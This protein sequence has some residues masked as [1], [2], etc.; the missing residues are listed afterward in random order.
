MLG[1]FK[2]AEVNS[3]KA[4]GPPYCH[5]YDDGSLYNGHF[6]VID[7]V[8]YRFEGDG[9]YLQDGSL[10]GILTDYYYIPDSCN[11]NSITLWGAL[12]IDVNGDSKGPNERGRDIFYFHVLDDGNLLPINSRNLQCSNGNWNDKN[13][14]DYG[15]G[16][17]G[18]SST[19]KWN[20][21]CAARIIEEG[22]KMN[23]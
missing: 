17:G 20:D 2:L 14:K 8:N 19:N 9:Y 23:Y 3:D 4:Y 15:E 16:M 21:G 10:F 12:W 5:E 6:S 1:A 7:I 13:W 11:D 22:W 18:C